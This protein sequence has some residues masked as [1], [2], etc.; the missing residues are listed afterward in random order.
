[1]EELASYYRNRL[2][3][4]V[5]I[6][7][8][9]A[10]LYRQFLADVGIWSQAHVTS[11]VGQETILKGAKYGDSIL[12]GI[13][14]LTGEWLIRTK[15]WKIERPSWNFSG[16]WEGAT[17]YQ[18]VEKSA[19]GTTTQV[20]FSSGKHE[21]LIEQ[22]CL[23][24]SVAPKRTGPFINWSSKTM[25]VLTLGTIGYAYEVNYNDLNRF[26]ATAIG[27]E[28]LKVNQWKKRWYGRRRPISLTGWFAHC[29]RG[30]VPVY[31][32]TVEFSLVKK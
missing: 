22:D 31:S 28:E 7:V 10:I 12:V 5:G 11:S 15:L 6:V 1:M 24:I 3:W 26:P 17:V 9:L 8:T 18:T 25:T 23:S 29:A 32:G 30:Q 21:I 19:P 2:K 14:F 27:Y 4:W 13:L 16:T 20:P